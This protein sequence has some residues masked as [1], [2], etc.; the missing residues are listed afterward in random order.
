METKQKK[1][2][3]LTK[4]SVVC[5]AFDTN[6]ETKF[7]WSLCLDVLFCD[8]RIFYYFAYTDL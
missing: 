3:Q 2:F 7:S 6:N 8:A 4:Q 5:G 1:L